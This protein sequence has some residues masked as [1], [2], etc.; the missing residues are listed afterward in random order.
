MIRAGLCVVV[1]RRRSHPRG[2]V[3]GSVQAV[4]H[5]LMDL[6]EPHS[7]THVAVEALPCPQRGNDGGRRRVVLE[8]EE[9]DCPV[10]GSGGRLTEHEPGADQIDELAGTKIVRVLARQPDGPVVLAAVPDAFEHE[11]L[12]VG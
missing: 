1:S 5:R 12:A 4:Q 6:D 11:T 3:E 8:T 10:A 7:V 9:L 2:G